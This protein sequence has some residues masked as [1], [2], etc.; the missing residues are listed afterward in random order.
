M[1]TESKFDD[2]LVPFVRDLLILFVCLLGLFATLSWV[3]DVNVIALVT[4]LGIGGL[5]L[6][7]AARETL[8]NLFASFAIVLDRPFLIGDSVSVGGVS[9]D[10]EQIGFRSTRIRTDDGSLLTVPN[11]LMINQSLDNTTQREAR[12]V[13]FIIRL[14]FDTPP[15]IIKAILQD[16]RAII[17]ANPDTNKRAN[18]IRFDNIGENAFEILILYHIETP[19][20][21]IF[22][23]KKE[24][25]NFEIMEIVHRHQAHFAL[26]SQVIYLQ[27]VPKEPPLNK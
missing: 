25:I 2:Q 24:V 1:L 5:A 10:V 19:A 6:A 8:E 16:I 20:I 15:D 11:R 21:A 18:H 3:Y 9:G 14:A 7:L 23:A 27:K 26:P 12:R 22:R 4:S 13:R 17:Q